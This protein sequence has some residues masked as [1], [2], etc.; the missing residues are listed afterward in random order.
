MP[1]WNENILEQTKADLLNVY[2][3]EIT[4][5]KYRNHPSRNAITEKM[6]KLGNPAFSFDSILYE[7]TVGSF[8]KNR[9]S[10]KICQGK[11]SYC[12]LFLVS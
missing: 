5:T 8:L 11:Y 1:L 7:E 12:P 9:Y 10:C 3:V 2:E 6:E 4:I